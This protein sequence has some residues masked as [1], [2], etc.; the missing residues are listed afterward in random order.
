[1]PRPNI[2]LI[3]LDTMRADRLGRRVGGR[4][5]T[6]HLND[7]ASRGR[8]WSRAVAAGVPTYFSFPA[9]FRGGRPLDAG[10]RIGLRDNTPT[11]I[12]RLRD[13]GYS[14]AAVVASNPYLSRYYGFDRGFDVYEDF[15]APGSGGQRAVVSRAERLLGPT[16][17]ARLRRLKARLNHLSES[18]GGGNPSIHAASRGESVTRRALELIESLDAPSFLWLHFMDQHGYYFSEPEDRERVMGAAGPLDRFG[19]RWKRFRYLSRWME[20]ILA[21]ESRPGPMRVEHTDEDVR[22]LTGFYDASVAYT[23]RWLGRLFDAVLPGNDTVVIVT[24]DHGEEFFEHGRIG[25]A[26]FSLYEE[27][28]RVPLV[29]AGP[30]VPEGTDDRWV[31]HAALPGTVLD[32]A[33]SATSE[34]DRGLLDG[35][36]GGPVLTESL[37]GLTTPFPREHL[38]EFNVVVSAR[39]GDLKLIHWHGA[40]R[41]EL[42]DLSND[43]GEM[44]DLADDPEHDETAEGLRSVVR[45]RVRQAARQDAR[46]DLERRVRAVRRRLE[47]RVS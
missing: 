43:P 38:A 34:D 35:E 18:F 9:I 44:R 3:T 36:P 15:G 47:E 41:E 6:P 17:T 29:M 39:A 20:L 5:L 22:C 25:H 45:D 24:S 27:L 11:F 14:T 26:P 16:T 1:M 40:D 2:I 7:L 23:D 31:S 19:L 12:E 28:V 10:K 33:G 21:S 37:W 8:T 4:E 46:F 13:S 32:M 42:Y 30:G